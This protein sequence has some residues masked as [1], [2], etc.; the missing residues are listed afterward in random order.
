MTM[1]T[2][3]AS[4]AS[5][6]ALRVG[7]RDAAPYLLKEILV[8][9]GALWYDAETWLGGLN[10]EVQYSPSEKRL[11]WRKGKTASELGVEAPFAVVNGR[12]LS[13][14]D[15]PKMVGARIAVTERFIKTNGVEFVGIDFKT[16]Q[17]EARLT[18]RIVIDPAY[19]GDDQ[20]PRTIDQVQAKK[21][22]LSLAKTIA[23]TFLREGYEVRLTRTDDVPMNN[24]RRAAVANNWNS[25]LFLSLAISGDRRPQAKGFETFYPPE[26]SPEADSH[27]WD[28]AQKGV[29]ERSRK[30][31]A[32]VENA[33]G[34]ALSMPD[35]GATELPN[36]LLASIDCPAAMLVLGNASSLQEIEMLI[37]EASRQKL[38][39]ALVDAANRFLSK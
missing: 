15:A 26:P 21:V 1:L 33:T 36:P 22:T 10:G 17:A 14:S 39:D 29:S 6:A 25:D 38:A 4:T 7:P 12:P 13:P 32:V 28:A 31:A 5:Q 37:D 18:P 11:Y 27:R 16:T 24:T 19:G 20:G 30:W 3:L 35:R 34:S 23:E 9:E 8:E 2:L